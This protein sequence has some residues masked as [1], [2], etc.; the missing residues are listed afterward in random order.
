MNYPRSWR[1]RPTAGMPNVIAPPEGRPWFSISNQSGDHAEVIIYDEIGYG[2]YTAQ[3]LVR[4]LRQLGNSDLTVRLNSPGG[5]VFDGL[6]V[7]NAIKRHPGY[8]TVHVD[9]LAASIASVIAMAGDRIVVARNAQMMVHDASGICIGNAADMR[10]MIA[11]LD[12]I[13]DTIAGVYAERAGGT[14]RQWRK[15]MQEERW[16]SADEAIAAGLADELADYEADRTHED[17][18]LAAVMGERLRAEV[19]A[20]TVRE[21]LREANR[22]WKADTARLLGGP[23]TLGDQL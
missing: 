6:A 11:L 13:S 5:E 2:G 10:E 17:F 19:Q 1:I 3:D 9:G 7:H 16:Y 4:E 12:R 21:A 18:D 15:T 8:V 14:A 20:A 22:Q 23:L